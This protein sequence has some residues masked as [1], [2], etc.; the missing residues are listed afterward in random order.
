MKYLIII[1]SLL[2]F[3]SSL[4]QSNYM[5]VGDIP[6]NNLI[7]DENFKLCDEYNIK[8]YYSRYSSD[9]PAGYLGEKREL[10]KPFFEG[11]KYQ[12]IESE[13]GYITIRFIVNCYGQSDR[14][15]I[16][17][18]D[19]SYQPKK[20]DP[21][22]CSQLLKITKQLKDWIPRNGN[23]QSYDFYQYLTFKI[24]NGQIIKILP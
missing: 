12:I 15:R 20:F 3:L 4:A 10:E 5:D 2:S 19:F 11:Y 6:F 7:D 24:K 9:T 22:I 18:M 21:K 14:F 8:Q 17:E 16:E 23:N 13:N 1:S